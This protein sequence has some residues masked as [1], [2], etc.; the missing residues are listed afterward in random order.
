MLLVNNYYVIFF[1]RKCTINVNINECP[2]KIV[3]YCSNHL[4]L[5]VNLYDLKYVIPIITHTEEN[6]LVINK[7]HLCDK[8]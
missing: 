8:L 5:L 3:K 2:I 6:M 1:S 7:L 4:L